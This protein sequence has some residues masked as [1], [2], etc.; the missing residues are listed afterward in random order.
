M[1]K[2]QS[3]SSTPADLI[4]SPTN[5]ADATLAPHL[6]KVKLQEQEGRTLLLS[7]SLLRLL[8]AENNAMPLHIAGT[9]LYGGI[10]NVPY[11]WTAIKVAACIGLAYLVK[12]FFSGTSNTS[13]RNMHGKVVMVTVR[14]HRAHNT[15]RPLTERSGRHQR[16]W[17]RSRSRTGFTRRS[18]NPPHATRPLRSFHRR[19]HRGRK[20]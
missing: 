15:G 9:A 6:E 17:R 4:L 19:L 5:P 11:L 2:K 10:D 20:K 3:R 14:R 18:D 13:E 1:L 8:R 7:N 12:A 16:R